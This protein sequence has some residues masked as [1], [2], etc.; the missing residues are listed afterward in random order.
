MNWREEAA[1]L[2]MIYRIVELGA[3][4]PV[5]D[6]NA[7][8]TKQCNQ[9]RDQGLL[10]VDEEGDW[11]PT[12][13]GRALNERMVN[14]FDR[15]EDLQIFEEV[16]FVEEPWTDPRTS[17]PAF[18]A[19]QDPYDLRV[20]ML[21][22]AVP[23]ASPERFV[24]L[25]NLVNGEYDHLDVLPLYVFSEVE[26]AVENADI[27]ENEEVAARVF[28]E[29]MDELKK[30]RGPVCGMCNSFLAL[31]AD[32]SQP[33]GYTPCPEDDC[34]LREGYEGYEEEEVIIT[35]T[36]VE[37]GDDYYDYDAYSYS[38]LGLALLL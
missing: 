10:V 35:E 21:Q 33:H 7:Q 14:L 1:A 3:H 5:V 12:D 29:G 22:H 15:I 16:D 27:I 25:V 26:Q 38:L 37:E 34:P 4:V 24:F 19:P 17:N 11:R 31:V 23:G 18:H 30:H 2:H 9:M 8:L 13:K 28:Q 6:V 36:Y 32:S 20:A